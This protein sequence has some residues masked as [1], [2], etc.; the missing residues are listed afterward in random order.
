MIYA[1]MPSPWRHLPQSRR[2]APFDI[3]PRQSRR[4]LFLALFRIRRHWGGAWQQGPPAERTLMFPL[5]L[6]ALRPTECQRREHG[7]TRCG[8]SRTFRPRNRI[9]ITLFACSLATQNTKGLWHEV[10]APPK[11]RFPG[12]G[13]RPD[14]PLARSGSHRIAPARPLAPA[15]RGAD[16]LGCSKIKNRS[17]PPTSG[18]LKGWVSLQ[19][20]IQPCRSCRT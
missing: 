16:P 7:A 13:E 9:S 2:P 18:G 8:P 11:R 14:Q 17:T 20:Q 3:N 19:A 6:N 10:G 4:Y 12:R 15:R 5:A 1:S